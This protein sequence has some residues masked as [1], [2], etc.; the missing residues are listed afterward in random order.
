MN[1]VTN[2]T[3]VCNQ[4]WLLGLTGAALMV[5][6]G[7]GKNYMSLVA[8]LVLVCIS[9]MVLNCLCMSGC[10]VLAWIYSLFFTVIFVAA[11]K[12]LPAGFDARVSQLVSLL[13]DQYCGLVQTAKTN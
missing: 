7:M 2:V 12:V 1:I 11:L 13:N 6:L 8:V 5:K 10:A 9:I 4:S 3:P